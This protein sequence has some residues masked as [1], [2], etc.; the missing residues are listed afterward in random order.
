[1]SKEI[2][3]KFVNPLYV[4][5]ELV[6]IG[7]DAT[8]RHHAIKKNT[9]KT[10][11]ITNL[12]PQEATI[13]KQS[14]LALGFD[15]AVHRGVLDCSVETSDAILSGSVVHFEKLVLSLE[16][17]PF[18]MK[19]VAQ[20]IKKLINNNL[21]TIKLNKNILDWSR[22]YIMGILNI[23]PDSFSDGGKFYDV[24]KAIT[25]FLQMIEDGADII[26]IGAES[27]RP[28]SGKITIE[29]EISRLKP[30]FSELKNI[31]ADVPISLD[32][33]NVET[34]RLIVDEFGVDIINDV[35]FDSINNEMIEFVNA[36]SIPY[37]YTHNK[38]YSKNLI[39][40]IYYDLSL[41]KEKIT[42][43]VIFDVG[44]G[45]GKTIEQNY[46]ILNRI[47]EFRGLNV[48]LLVGHSRKSYLS[49]C[50]DLQNEQ[51]DE[52]T[53]FISAKL[54]ENEVNILRVHDAKIHK[55]LIDVYS[56]FC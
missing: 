37:I 31:N 33:R 22:P 24:E 48:P 44:I 6:K 50:F 28:N 45:F 27:T 41:M 49:K 36:Y 35:G 47:S 19:K 20:L 16:K 34:A 54:I 55:L 1:M 8:Y 4:E 17:Q 30:I 52:A 15:A 18:K 29:E 32:T 13:L 2:I 53:A 51:L 46:E 43:P 7:F 56:K 14:A 38:S 26:D 21:S 9:L 25:H 23:T 10:I 5:D 12:R 40:N 42:A 3:A 39:D 11:K